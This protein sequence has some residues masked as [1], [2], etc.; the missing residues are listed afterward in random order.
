ML[1]LFL[2][3]KENIFQILNVED[4]KKLKEHLKTIDINL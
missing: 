3:Q 2:L 4:D 1:I